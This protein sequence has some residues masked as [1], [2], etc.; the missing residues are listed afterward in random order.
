MSPEYRRKRA[1]TRRSIKFCSSIRK[2]T[3]RHESSYHKIEE[4]T[5]TF[6]LSIH[7]KF[8][9]ITTIILSCYQQNAK[10]FHIQKAVNNAFHQESFVKWM[11]Q[12]SDIIQSDSVLRDS[13]GFA[14]LRWS[15]DNMVGHLLS[16]FHVTWRRSRPMRKDVIYNVFSRWLKSNECDL[17]VCMKMSHDR[18]FWIP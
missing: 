12:T 13:D 8:A 5:I 17:M 14:I 1:M 16:N 18:R 7:F 9:L 2:S 11:L 3:F 10:V 4:P 6:S 15:P